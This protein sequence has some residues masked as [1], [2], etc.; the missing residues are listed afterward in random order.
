MYLSI[1]HIFVPRSLQLTY[2]LL[3]NYLDDIYDL[4]VNSLH[5]PRT[6]RLSIA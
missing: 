2:I 4:I 1:E 5:G 3:D 6:L